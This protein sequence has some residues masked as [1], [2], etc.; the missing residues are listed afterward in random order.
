MKPRETMFVVIASA[1][2][3]AGLSSLSPTIGGRAA[4]VQDGRDLSRP[5]NHAGTQ[6]A[7]LERRA[8]WRGHP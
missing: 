6:V 2:S 3:L 8:P 7:V 1:V 5:A 4:V